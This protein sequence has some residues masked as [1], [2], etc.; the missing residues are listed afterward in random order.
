ME[1][2]V[3]ALPR[4]ISSSEREAAM[5]SHSLPSFT[6]LFADVD[7]GQLNTQINFNRNSVFFV[8]NN[9]T[10]GHICNDI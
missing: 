4:E 9:S 2:P 1:M 6:T 8:C 7:T 3:A 5:F 10:T